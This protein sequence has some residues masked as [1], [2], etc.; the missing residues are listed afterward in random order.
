MINKCPD[1]GG[2]IGYK[3]GCNDRTVYRVCS[4]CKRIFGVRTED[5]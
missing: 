3:L 4:K 1:C 5:K 2:K